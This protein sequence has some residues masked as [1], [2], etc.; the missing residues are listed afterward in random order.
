V[1]SFCTS[2]GVNL[3]YVDNGQ[4]HPVV[5]IHGYTTDCKRRTSNWPRA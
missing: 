4:G 2:D 5:L 1:S 3:S